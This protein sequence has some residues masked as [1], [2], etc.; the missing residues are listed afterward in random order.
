M[1]GLTILSELYAEKLGEARKVAEPETGL[2]DERDEH[3][4]QDLRI[5]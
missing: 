3:D 2:H 4:E 1:R 5:E